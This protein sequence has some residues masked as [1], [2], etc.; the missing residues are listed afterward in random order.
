MNS[1]V[2][3]SLKCKRD[4]NVWN[5]TDLKN[6]ISFKMIIISGMAHDGVLYAPICINIFRAKWLV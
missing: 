3:K 4:E 2:K 1:I 5:K 6:A